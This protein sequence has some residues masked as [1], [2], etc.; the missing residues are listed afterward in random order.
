LSGFGAEML[1]IALSP[2]REICDRMLVSG[3]MLLWRD[4]AWSV[5]I[6]ALC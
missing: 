4:V 6:C 5:R 1:R 2:R 3:A